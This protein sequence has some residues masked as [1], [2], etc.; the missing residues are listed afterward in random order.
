[1]FK[2]LGQLLVIAALITAIGG[3]WAALQSLAWTTMLA[4]NLRSGSLSEAVQRTFDG[5]HPCALCK[6]IAAGKKSEQKNSASLAL[7][8]FEF[9]H[10]GVVFIFRSPTDFRLLADRDS[11]GRLRSQLPPVPPPRSLLP[12]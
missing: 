11:A 5:R 9:A 4:D 1:V 3:H 10:L 7:K 8:K 2:R 6:Q 12:G